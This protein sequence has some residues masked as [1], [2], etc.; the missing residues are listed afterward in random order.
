MEFLGEEVDGAITAQK[1]R[2]ETLHNPKYITSA[3]ALLVKFKQS[4]SA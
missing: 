3:A 4:K 1:T 2:R